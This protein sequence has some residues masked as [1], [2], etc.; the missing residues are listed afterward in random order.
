MP[1]DSP[2]TK[3]ELERIAKCMEKQ[4]FRELLN[5]YLTA[6]QDPETKKVFHMNP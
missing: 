2:P 4:E 6:M 3:E 5:E 1:D